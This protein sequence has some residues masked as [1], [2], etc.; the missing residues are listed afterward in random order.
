MSAFYYFVIPRTHRH[1]AYPHSLDSIWHHG[2]V[3]IKTHTV[4]QTVGKHLA[5]N[6]FYKFSHRRE[7]GIVAMVT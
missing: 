7:V 2:I 1:T 3:D 4:W 5:C 6:I